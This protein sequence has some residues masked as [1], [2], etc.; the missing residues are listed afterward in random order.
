MV[1]RGADHNVVLFNDERFRIE[2]IHSFN[3]SDLSVAGVDVTHDCQLSIEFKKP[4]SLQE[5]ERIAFDLE[6][7]FSFCCCF[8][9]GLQRIQV[10]FEEAPR[11][12]DL[13]LPLV[14]G[15]RPSDRQLAFLPLTYRWFDGSIE[16]SLTAWMNADDALKACFSLLTSLLFRSWKLP[17][18]LRFIA[19]SQLLEAVSKYGTELKATPVDEYETYRDALKNAIKSIRNKEIRRWAMGRLPGNQKGQKRLLIE[20]L[21]RNPAARDWLFP[22]AEVFVS[23]HIAARNYYTHRNG[24][25]DQDV[26]TQADLHWHTECILLF[27]YVVIAGLIGLEASSVTQVLQKTAFMSG[28]RWHGRKLYSKSDADRS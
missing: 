13:Y 22:S 26:L 24:N 11:Y 2:L 15:K 7:F 16:T 23:K 21:D 9:A 12:A 6:G 1:R 25:S 10:T 17:V 3:R 14:E 28:A 5:V 4:Y 27:C 18:D 8:Y 20:L 19:A